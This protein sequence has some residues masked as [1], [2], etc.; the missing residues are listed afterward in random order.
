MA[1]HPWEVQEIENGTLIRFTQRE[2]DVETAAVLIDELTAFA[3]EG[4]RLPV[5]LDL[6]LV[7][8]LPSLVI[9]KLLALDHRLHA[10]RSRLYLCNL[11]PF[12]VELLQVVRWPDALMSTASPLRRLPEPG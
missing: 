10:L 4:G 12:V 6:G 5:Y 7:R 8:F 11:D 1:P 9:G 3:L 2:L